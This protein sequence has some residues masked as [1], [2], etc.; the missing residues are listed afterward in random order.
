MKYSS[1]IGILLL[2]IG[3]VA[4]F[5]AKYSF[6]DLITD[7][8]FAVGLSFGGGAGLLFGGFLGWLYKRPKAKKGAEAKK[9]NTETS[10]TNSTDSNSNQV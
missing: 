6:S 7:P 9:A 2:L 3:L 5:V 1:I 4:S 10:T 8:E